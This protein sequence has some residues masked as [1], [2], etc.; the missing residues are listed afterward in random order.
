MKKT[1]IIGLISILVMLLI[2]FGCSIEQPV[3]N[4]SA[5]IDAANLA[6]ASSVT[7]EAESMSKSGYSNESN[8]NASGSAVIKLSGT[9][10]SVTKN[11]SGVTSTYN[12]TVTYIDQIT[13]SATFTLSIAGTVIGT[14]TGDQATTADLFLTKTFSNISV[15]NGAQIKLSGTKSGTE[16]AK[17]DV[18]S[19]VPTT[20]SSVSSSTGVSSSS[21][22][23]SSKISSSVAS[24]SKASSSITSSVAASSSSKISSSS[25]ASSSKAASSSS[26]VAS[27]S[28]PLSVMYVSPS[29]SDTNSGT[30]LETPFYSLH[31]A[32]SHAVAGSVIYMRGGTY[33]YTSTVF[34]W[35]A[36]TSSS[37]IK[38][39]A[40]NGEKPVLSYAGWSPATETL[41][42]VARGI[43]VETSAQYWYIK[44]IEICYA[45]D[46]GCKCEGGYTTFDQ[47][48]FHHNG[49]S[50]LQVGLNKDTLS[51]NPDPDH[52]AAYNQVLN[53]DSYRNADPATDYENADGFACK[54]YAGKGNYFYGC[55]SWENCDDGWDCY[56]S[57]YGPTIENCWAWHNGDPSIWGFTSFNGDGNGFK[58]GGDNT[59]MPVTV[60]NSIALNC[61]YGALG[62]FAYNNNTAPITLLN[63][64]AINC[65]RPYKMLQDSNIITNCVDLGGT[66]AAPKDISSSSTCTNC[67]WT[68]G[69]TA[70]AADFV[71]ILEAD[72]VADRQSDGS[73]PTNFGRLVST[74]QLIDKGINVGIS[75]L[76][77]APDLGAYEK[78]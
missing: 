59:Y 75:Y 69:I 23:S 22:V 8:S 24:S 78:Q 67:T 57:D 6:T 11:F 18:L 34:L 48:V 46:N 41:R 45:P 64:L 3:N 53:C 31:T 9:S 68:L 42:G 58:L 36:G 38:I 4:D 20:S 29:G 39:L 26:S 40:Y 70:T 52:Y 50:G 77:S 65:G 60:K 17:F 51:S 5:V 25:K 10:G 72:A 12:I 15:A 71:S 55:R 73:L 21:V 30:S 37:P 13:D 2:P 62:G 74:S 49:D 35:Q 28:D 44:G 61:Q 32:V 47:V 43:K 56:Q 66:R 14:W 1:Q 7:L 16:L 54:L 63:C 33:N 19:F 27:V 76:G